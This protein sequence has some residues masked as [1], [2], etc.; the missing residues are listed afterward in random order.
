[1]KRIWTRAAA[2]AALCAVL[3]SGCSFT[4]DNLS[5]SAAPADP[6]TGQ[7]LQYP[8]E[9]TAAV[10][11]DNAPDNTTQWGIGSASVVLEAQTVSGLPTSLCLVY[12]SVSAMPTVGPVTLGQDLY[13][14]LLSGQQVI[15]VQRGCGLYTRNYLDY[16]NLR[17]VDALEVGRNSF[18]ADEGWSNSPLWRTSGKA[19]MGVLDSLNI[20]SSL[21]SIPSASSA[22]ASGSSEETAADLP[23]LPAL[24][25]QKADPYLPD[26]GAEDAVQVQVHFQSG[27]STGFAYDAAQGTYGMLHTDG[28]PQID[29]NTGAQAQ[30]DN[31]LILYSGSALRDD[32]RTLDYDLSLG[33]GVWL[34][35]GCL[36]HITWTQGTDS[37]FVFYDADGNLL[38]LCSGRSYLA[39][40]SSVTGE[41]LSVQNSAGESLLS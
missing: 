20:S 36:W 38:T 41:E 39:L 40:V 15:P 27:T 23:V 18:T 29:A 34:H 13:W 16:Y 11:I 6:L 4:A 1:M 14:R 25:P 5:G 9:R 24:L 22:A 33:G 19:V 7:E 10:V 32:S 8:G 3:L 28:T 26:P 21:N 12:P 35:G 37:T 2:A 17:A 30:F 31:L